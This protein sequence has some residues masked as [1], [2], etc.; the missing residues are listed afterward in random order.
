M[1]KK[2]G[3]V[4]ISV[5]DEESPPRLFF[6]GFEFQEFTDDKI[7]DCLDWIQSALCNAQEEHNRT[8]LISN[9]AEIHF[10]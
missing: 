10:V 9:R 7:Q 8:R 5:T 3:I 6:Q 1:I 4:T 2:H